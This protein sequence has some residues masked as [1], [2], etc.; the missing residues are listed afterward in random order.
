M[1]AYQ[2]TAIA[3]KRTSPPASGRGRGW[4]RFP[5]TR[6]TARI[7]NTGRINPSGPLVSTA[8]PLTPHA[9]KN[10]STDGH[11]VLI[12]SQTENTDPHNT[13]AISHSDRTILDETK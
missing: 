5:R 2:G 3:A 13:A 12:A 7:A 11:P 8:R 9:A 6:S 10:H 4:N 1:I